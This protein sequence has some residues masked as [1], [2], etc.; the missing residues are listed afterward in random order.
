MDLC[1]YMNPW[2][3]FYLVLFSFL[4]LYYLSSYL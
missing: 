1:L 2:L 3:F 4:I